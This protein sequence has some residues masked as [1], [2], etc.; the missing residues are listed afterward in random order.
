LSV[1]EQDAAVSID[2]DHRVRGR[3]EQAPELFL[4]F[5]PLAGVA[6]RAR[7]QGAVLGIQRAQADL[8]GKFGTVLAPPVELEAGAH[9][10]HAWIGEEIGAVS[11]VLSAEPLGDEHLDRAAVQ[12]GPRIT[13]KLLRLG[14]GQVDDAV[15]VDDD[16][17]VRSR[18]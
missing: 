8:D 7:N 5:F 17:G 6:D 15:A 4:C 9:R 18:L 14:V 11:R 1:D 16:D 2:D 13:E 3:L 10:P 12:L